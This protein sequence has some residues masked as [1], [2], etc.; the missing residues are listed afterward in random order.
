MDGKGVSS[1]EQPVFV[2]FEIR[3]KQLA[4]VCCGIPVAVDD[5]AQTVSSCLW[6]GRAGSDG[7]TAGKF[8]L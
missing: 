3:S 7:W 1:V 8:Q 4:L 5:F 6:R 2:C